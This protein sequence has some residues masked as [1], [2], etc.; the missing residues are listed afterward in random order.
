M[1]VVVQHRISVLDAFF[2]AASTAADSAPAGV[3]GRQFCPS[4]GG[5]DAVCLW[6]ADSIEAVRDYLDA[7]VGDGSENAYFEVDTERAIGIPEPIAAGAR[8]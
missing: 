6:E 4:R 5:R 2:S 1:Y 3:Y 8:V 7:L